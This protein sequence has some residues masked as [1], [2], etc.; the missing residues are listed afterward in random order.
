[1]SLTSDEG[2][3]GHNGQNKLTHDSYSQRPNENTFLAFCL[4]LAGLSLCVKT[5]HDCCIISQPGHLVERHFMAIKCN[6]RDYAK[7]ASK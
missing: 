6:K 4:L 7:G 5:L 3:E 2:V 1:M